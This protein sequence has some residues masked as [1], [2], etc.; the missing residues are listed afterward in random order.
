[1]SVVELGPE[2]CE[3]VVRFFSSLTEGDLT[4]F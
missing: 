4:F 3:A 2:H 1:M